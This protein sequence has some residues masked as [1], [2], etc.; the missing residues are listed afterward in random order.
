MTH[1]ALLRG[2]NVGGRAAVDMRRLKSTFERLGFAGVRTYINSGNVIFRVPGGSEGALTERMEAAIAE[3]F[4]LQVPV[5]LR[6]AEELGL[7]VDAVP[8]GWV[9]D[10]SMRCD[11]LFL[12]PEVDRP[13]VLD[14]VPHKP[15]IEDLLYVPGA[16]VR[17]ID[18]QNVTKSP[19]AR[20]AGS[21]LYRRLTMRNITTV[22]KLHELATTG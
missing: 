6:T 22:R 4:G 14:D 5:L 21:D 3:D 13:S 1:V 2:V 9:N 7:V 8:A 12:W 16:V 17:R 15:A 11:V 19:L 18:R 20:I 10:A